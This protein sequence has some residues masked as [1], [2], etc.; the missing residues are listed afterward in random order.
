MREM[1]LPLSFALSV[2]LIVAGTLA[3]PPLTGVLYL[4]AVLAGAGS[5]Y[6]LLDSSGQEEEA[7]TH[8]DSNRTWYRAVEHLQDPEHADTDKATSS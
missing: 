5:A 6:F 7:A 2:V 4:V 1:V 8:P 3:S